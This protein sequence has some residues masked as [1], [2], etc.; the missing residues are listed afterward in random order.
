MAYPYD[1]EPI[2]SPT[3]AIYGRIDPPEDIEPVTLGD[4]M[5][6]FDFKNDR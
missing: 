1:D 5:D 3:A 4:L 6:E 2:G